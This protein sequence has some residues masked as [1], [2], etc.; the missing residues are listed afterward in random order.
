M[1]V[2]FDSLSFGSLYRRGIYFQ[3]AKWNGRFIYYCFLHITL[4]DMTTL[5]VRCS[6]FRLCCVTWNILGMAMK[7]VKHLVTSVIWHI[8]GQF[9]NN[10]FI[11]WGAIAFNLLASPNS[12]D[13]TLPF[14][15]GQ[16][17]TFW[18]NHCFFLQICEEVLGMFCGV[19]KKTRHQTW[20]QLLMTSPLPMLLLAF[21]C[22]ALPP[23][24]T[25]HQCISCKGITII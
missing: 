8:C 21:L 7:A 14:V 2:Y 16:G 19:C 25:D 17:Y 3:K 18:W 22:L 10:D 5:W 11:D 13:Y 4:R 20:S 9:V 24:N 6:W 15:S 1:V 23:I 12:S